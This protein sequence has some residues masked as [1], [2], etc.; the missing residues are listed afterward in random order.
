MI[1]YIGLFLF[2]CAVFLMNRKQNSEMYSIFISVTAFF[3]LISYILLFA[4]F[5]TMKGKGKMNLGIKY[6]IILLYYY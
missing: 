6:C 2:S 5:N 4:Y 1:I 3:Y